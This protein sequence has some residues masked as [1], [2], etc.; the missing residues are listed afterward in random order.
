VEE[1]AWP[2]AGVWL[3]RVCQRRPRCGAHILCA[4]HVS[5]PT[6]MQTLV[7]PSHTH[8]HTHTQTHTQTH[9]HTHGVTLTQAGASTALLHLV[10]YRSPNAAAALERIQ[11]V[12]G[13]LVSGEVRVAHTPCRRPQ[14]MAA[15]TK[16][17]EE[18][19][20]AIV[21]GTAD[22]LCLYLTLSL[23]V[24]LSFPLTHCGGRV[25]MPIDGADVTAARCGVAFAAVSREANF[26]S[27]ATEA[28]LR[29]RFKGTG[30]DATRAYLTAV[31]VWAMDAHAPP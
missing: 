7:C 6:P 16:G 3:P 28:L 26:E 13:G 15:V 31:E 11:A 14:R 22:V 29:D 2:G 30:A 5:A 1:C 8:T 9:A 4:C 18:D 23:R 17:D 20:Y 10:V 19:G 25:Q 24:C 12:I 27:A 21:R